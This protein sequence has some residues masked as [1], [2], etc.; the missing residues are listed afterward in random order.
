M[1][2]LILAAVKQFYR[3]LMELKNSLC[4]VGEVDGLPCI[5]A[6]ILKPIHGPKEGFPYCLLP[7][8]TVELQPFQ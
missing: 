4:E 2:V 5:I 3:T 1:L 8:C 6:S 7:T